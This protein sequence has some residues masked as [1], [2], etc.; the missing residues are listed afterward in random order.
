MNIDIKIL[1]QI[2]ANQLQEYIKRIEYHYQVGWQNIK[3]QL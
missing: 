3:N 2:L 1:N